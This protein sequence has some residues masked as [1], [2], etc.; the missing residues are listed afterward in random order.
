MIAFV[1]ALCLC[2]GLALA[3]MP[4]SA[5]VGTVKWVGFDGYGVILAFVIFVGATLALG[6]QF[7]IALLTGLVLHEAGH[8]L[9]ARSLNIGRARFR[10]APMLS[11]GW[12][13]NEDPE[14][15]A[16]AFFVTL[17]GAGLSLAPMALSITLA[18]ALR[19]AAP[20]AADFLLLFGA[21]LGALNFVMLLPV[22]PLDGAR[23]AQIATRGFWPELAPGL[24]LF[25]SAAALTAGIKHA[26]LALVV[27]A[28]VGVGSLLHRSR[29]G[30]KM[31][32]GRESLIALAAYT[33]TMAAH[34]SAGWLLFRLVV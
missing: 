17:M 7:A 5:T 14:T 23:C 9:A 29:D 33:F 20:E 11:D 12:V 28:L 31:M 26:S 24:T 34:F 1:I 4:R 27:L 21:T 6:N 15:D 25:M 8:V 2:V 19:G 13:L 10:L 16:E 30:A 18:V 32:S 3:I 22:W